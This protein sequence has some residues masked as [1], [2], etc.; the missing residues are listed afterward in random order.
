MRHA[1]KMD[2]CIQG[3]LTYTAKLFRS[4]SLHLYGPQKSETWDLQGEGCMG[5]RGV[6]RV[7]VGYNT[8]F[9]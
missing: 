3:S 5:W 1:P 9:P 2:H 6:V 7:R 8:L 4:I